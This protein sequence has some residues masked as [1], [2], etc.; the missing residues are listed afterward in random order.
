MNYF[1][2]IQ[3]PVLLGGDPPAENAENIQENKKDISQNTM[4]IEALKKSMEKGNQFM[5]S[6]FNKNNSSKIFMLVI[7]LVVV[8]YILNANDWKVKKIFNSWLQ[9]IIWIFAIIRIVMLGSE[10]YNSL[11]SESSSA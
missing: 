5:S 8:F 4:E 2:S 3:M 11:P 7:F 10:I 1:E 6:I 9:T